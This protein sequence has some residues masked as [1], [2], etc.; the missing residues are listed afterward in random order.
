MAMQVA[1]T[2]TLGD[3]I[4]RACAMGARLE[5]AG[6]KAWSEEFGDWYVPEYLVCEESHV[7]LPTTNDRD[8]MLDVAIVNFIRTRLKLS[9]WPVEDVGPPESL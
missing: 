5:K 6:M 7:P 9:V 3:L 8:Y 2:M 4:D 1:G